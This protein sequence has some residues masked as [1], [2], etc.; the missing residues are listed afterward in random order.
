MSKNENR[1]R[2]FQADFIALIYKHGFESELFIVDGENED[3][4]RIVAFGLRGDK[5]GMMLSR[6]FEAEPKDLMKAF[7]ISDDCVEG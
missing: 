1:L 7:G 6:N 3:L 4:M 2:D 5:L